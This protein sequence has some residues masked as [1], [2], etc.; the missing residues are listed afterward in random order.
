MI[1]GE[2]IALS[3]KD[4]HMRDAALSCFHCALLQMPCYSGDLLTAQL[5]SWSAN[6]AASSKW[7][8]NTYA[9]VDDYHD[10]LKCIIACAHPK[11]SHFHGV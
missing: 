7:V 5:Y 6:Y 1:Y 9:K 11:T 2:N 3:I 8:H 4:V 10:V